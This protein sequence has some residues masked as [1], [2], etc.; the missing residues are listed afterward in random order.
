MASP[1]DDVYDWLRYEDRERDRNEQ[2]RLL[3]VAA[4]RARES[5]HL[6]MVGGFSHLE[7]K[8][9]E[10]AAP[11]QNSLLGPIWPAIAPDAVRHPATEIANDLPRDAEP[12]TRPVLQRLPRDYVWRP[13]IETTDVRF[14]D[15]LPTATSTAEA[16][17][18]S[19]GPQRLD[20]SIGVAVHEA[21]RMLAE[22]P[23]PEDAQRY[24]DSAAPEWNNRL[25][26]LG[27]DGADREAA[28]ATLSQQL[29][30][31]LADPDGRW[32]LSAHREAASEAPF[33]LVMDGTL[34]NIVVDRTF[35]DDAGSRWIIDFNSSRPH[36]DQP[37]D[38][39]IARQLRSY[40]AQLR[41][42][43]RV[44]GRMDSAAAAT[45]RDTQSDTQNSSPIRAALYFTAIGRLVELDQDAADAEQTA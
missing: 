44:L 40:T 35:F 22:N 12:E 19:A 28:V 42:Y 29:M 23:L 13:P 11:R 32:L 16:L 37:L 10:I 1:G 25:L 33:T 18:G 43:R 6:S 8:A 3:Y 21:L 26:E 39:F 7:S 41:R 30:T 38:E 24:V 4:T 14:V 9:A 20:I 17:T 36:V 15:P 5:L 45:Q 31:T 2:L 34:T 27:L